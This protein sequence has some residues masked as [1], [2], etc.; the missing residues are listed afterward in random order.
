MTCPTCGMSVPTGM[1]ACPKCGTQ[2]GAV[3]GVGMP[4]MPGMPNLPGAMG[5]MGAPRTS[6]L[7]IA[8]FVCSFFCSLLGLVL[9]ILGY[10]ECKRSNGMVKGTGLAIAGM[11]ISGIFMIGGI[12]AA[13]AIPAFMDYMHKSK[14]T[15]AS[16]QMNKIG[17]NAK[18]YYITDGKF[19]VFDQPLTPATTCCGQPNNKCPVIP[20]QWQTE[21]WQALDFQ[22]DEPHLYQY[23]YKSDGTTLDAYAVGDLDCDG[24]AAT[25]HLHLDAPNGNPRMVLEEPRPGTY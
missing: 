16:L 2:V 3:A 8:G 10:S 5:Q 20:A 6:G 15:E 11:V 19:P 22:A 23:S 1:F 9:S 17:K 24:T 18:V 21:A 14:K 13:I 7:A 4:G 12:L 25:Y